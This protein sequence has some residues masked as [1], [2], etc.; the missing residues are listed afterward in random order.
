MCS[1]ITHTHIPLWDLPQTILQ[2]GF[3]GCSAVRNL[4]ASTG[5]MGLIPEWARSPAEGNGYPF[6]YSCRGNFMDRGA[7]LAIYSLWGLKELHMT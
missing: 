4:L 1:Q 3:P 2:K 5:D 6:Q 7:C